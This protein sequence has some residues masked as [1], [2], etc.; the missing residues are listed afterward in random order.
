MCK[1]VFSDEAT[2]KKLYEALKFLMLYLVIDAYENIKSAQH[3]PCFYHFLFSRDTSADPL[4]YMMNHLNT[5]G[6]TSELEQV[7]FYCHFF[8][9]SPHS[10]LRSNMGRRQ[11]KFK[12]WHYCY[13]QTTQVCRFKLK[14]VEG[15]LQSQ[16]QLCGTT[17]TVR[18]ENGP[19]VRW[20]GILPPMLCL[21]PML[22]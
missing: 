10:A 7:V 1:S 3:S 12:K 21:A 9:S 22:N 4:S 14:C 8:T 13:L 11:G 19:Y 2:E 18:G 16:S 20:G 17:G 6:D 15:S 5:V